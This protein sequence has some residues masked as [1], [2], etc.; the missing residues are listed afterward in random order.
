MVADPALPLLKEVRSDDQSWKLSVFLC[1][2]VVV[3]QV[4]AAYI[5]GLTLVGA[6]ARMRRAH[7]QLEA[8]TEGAFLLKDG[9]V[10]QRVE[11]LQELRELLKQ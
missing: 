10:D 11:S 2:Y 5:P 3:P 7:P 9:R 6:G 1:R 4:G 8:L